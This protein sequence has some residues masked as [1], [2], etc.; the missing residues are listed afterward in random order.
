M[1]GKCLKTNKVALQVIDL[2]GEGISASDYINIGRITEFKYGAKLG[3]VFRRWDGEKL[4]Y[5]K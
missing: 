1:W 4:A 3:K 5:L 2:G